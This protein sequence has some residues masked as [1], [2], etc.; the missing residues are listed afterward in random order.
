M[1]Y[2]ILLVTLLSIYTVLAQ[3][4]LSLQDAILIGLE[5]NYNIRVEQQNVAIAKNN[6]NWGQAGLFPQLTFNLNQNN[7]ITDNVKTASPFAIK[8]QIYA[9]SISPGVNLNWNL[10]SGFKVH[11]TKARLDQLQAETE[12]N[13]SIVVANNIQLIILGYYLAALEQQRLEVYLKQLNLSRD[14]YNYVKAGVELGTGATSDLLIEEGN[15]LTDSSNYINQQ[16]VFRNSLRNLNVLLA[17]KDVNKGYILTDLLVPDFPE[18]ELDNLMDKMLENNVDIKKQYITQSILRSDVSLNKA[19]RYPT[20]AL[21]AG[22]SRNSGRNNLSRTSF[23]D[24][25]RAEEQAAYQANPDTVFV[26]TPL[27]Y[28]APLKSVSNNFFANFTLSFNLFNGG[29]INRAIKNSIIQEQIGEIQISQMKNT[30]ERDLLEAY[31][32]YQSRRHLYG[33]DARREK[34][35]ATNLEISAAK[36]R[37]GSINSFDYRIVQNTHLSASIQKLQALYNLMDSKVE[38]MRLT[39]GLVE[40]YNQ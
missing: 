22:V 3:E 17:E 4:P 6:N 11:I 7:G 28:L 32:R 36:F 21:N 13:A 39:G 2:F 18:Y 29:Q 26:P 14:K 12:G 34:V 35:A 5:R 20:L 15:Y 37:N 27:D 16:L 30:L 40:E 10:F 19:Q 33:I 9:N 38:L 1:R 8:G 31:D 23:G 25:Q 24:R